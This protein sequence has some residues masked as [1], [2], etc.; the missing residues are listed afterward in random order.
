MADVQLIH[1]DCLDVLKTLDAGSIDAVV[2]DPP[3]GINFINGGGRSQ[4]AGWRDARGD[5]DWDKYRPS[6]EIF[7]EI[8][9]IGRKVIVWGGNYFTDYLPPSMQW[10]VWDKCQ[11]DFSLADCELAWSNQDRAARVFSFP[12]GA[13]QSERVNHPTQ[14]PVSLMKWCI[15]LVTQPGD[16]ILDPFMG[17]GTTGVAA[18][19]TGRRFIGCEIDPTYFAIAEK[20]IAEAQLQLPLLEATHG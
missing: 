16:T 8:L 20:R 7:D 15:E 6:K 10:L 4:K 9:R 12:R 5:G 3:Y 13:M 2:T 14:K 11:R 17:S 1:G 18:V 19:K